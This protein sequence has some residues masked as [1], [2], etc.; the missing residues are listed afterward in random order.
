MH[1]SLPDIENMDHRFK[2]N[3]INSLSGFKSA[4]L[5]GSIDKNDQHNLAI[6]S[7]VFHLG[8]DPALMGF[9][10]RP[11][12]VE[13]HTLS[14]IIETGFFTLNNVTQSMYKQ[15]HQTSA[16]YAKTESEFDETG[17]IPIFSNTIAAPYVEQSTVRIGLELVEQSQ[18]KYNNTHLVIG[19]IVEVIVQDN[20][21]QNDGYIDIEQ[22]NTVAVSGLDNYHTTH[23]LERLAYAKSGVQPKPLII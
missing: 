4:N 9:I 13:R 12:S 20:V 8:A 3:F 23:R 6:I 19:K 17:L 21:I 15:A 22:L 18:I 14:N 5:V 1:F 11:D 16:R 10:N 7:S 2:V